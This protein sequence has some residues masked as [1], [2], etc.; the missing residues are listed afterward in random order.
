MRMGLQPVLLNDHQY[1]ERTRD[2]IPSNAVLS[3]ILTLARADAEDHLCIVQ[4]PLL[5]QIDDNT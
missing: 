4:N 3:L 2:V 1:N 5:Y